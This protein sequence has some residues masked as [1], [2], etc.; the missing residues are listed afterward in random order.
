DVGRGV[1]CPRDDLGAEGVDGANERLVQRLA[2]LPQCLR[3][4]IL[5]RLLGIARLD[6]GE[7]AAR[8]VRP[9]LAEP[10]DDVKG[11]A[12]NGVSLGFGPWSSVSRSRSSQR[13]SRTLSST[14]TLRRGP[15][16]SSACASVGIGSPFVRWSIARSRARACAIGKPITEGS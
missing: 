16:A 6:L 3:A 2:L 9:L 1:D 7:H 11:E 10:A 4:C 15:T 12:V 14:N 5:E 8:Q 13:G